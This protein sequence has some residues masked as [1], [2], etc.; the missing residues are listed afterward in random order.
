MRLIRRSGLDGRQAPRHAAASLAGL[1]GSLVAVVTPFR[2]GKVDVAA[3]GTLCERQITRG[4]SALVMCGSTGEAPAL[5]APEQALIVTTAVS[6]AAGRIPVIAGCGASATEAATI[7]AQAAARSGAA[8]LLCAPPL[9]SKP[10]QEGIVAHVRAVSHAADRPVILYDVPSRTGVAIHDE[11]VARLFEC[12]LVSA[13]KDAAGDT[14]RPVRLRALCGGDLL[15]FSG[16]DSDVPA[17]LVMGGHGCISVT[18]NLTPA[19]CAHLHGAWHAG[20]TVEFGRLRDLLA[21][22]HDALFTESNPIPVKA[23]LSQAGLCGGDLR[24]PLTRASAVTLECLAALLPVLL[25][26]ED[27]AAGLPRLSLVK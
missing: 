19:L 9:Y 15:Q 6:I 18:A 17:H 12:G 21:P 16:N 24:L 27:A 7:L 2:N 22:L 23:A 25:A 8:A 14:S 1:Y 11:T 3:L 13:I 5:S 10:T 4:S 20:D 26:A